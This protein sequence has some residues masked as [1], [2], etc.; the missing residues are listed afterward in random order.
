MSETSKHFSDAEL[1]CKGKTCG[2]LHTGCHVNYCTPELVATLERIRLRTGPLLVDS[3]YRCAQH[4]AELVNAASFSRHVTG[5]AADIRAQGM[6]A[7]D[8]ETIAR[9][10][11][12]ING[13]GRADAQRYIHIDLR[14]G[15]RV[16]WCYN[17][18]GAEVAYYLPGKPSD[19]TNV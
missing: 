16:A 8:L 10:L 19:L 3:G 13:I 1:E 14:P 9:G 12:E 17:A 4:N 2:P 15:P 5:Q 18:A 7:A 6:S 11:P